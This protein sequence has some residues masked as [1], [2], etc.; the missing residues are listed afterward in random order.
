MVTRL[1][2]CMLCLKS[3]HL[4]KDCKAPK[5]TLCQFS[6]HEMLHR[7]R[8]FAHDN[9]NDGTG[10]EKAGENQ[11]QSSLHVS[12]RMKPN[13]TEVFLVTAK[14]LV[15]DVGGK[16][17]DVRVILDSAS[18]LNLVYEYMQQTLRLRK[19]AC[20]MGVSLVGDSSTTMSKMATTSV[21]SLEIVLS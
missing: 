6:H 8:E 12:T 21:K 17:H 11:S 7:Q 18:Q 10:H 14:I 3:G 19:V 16:Y 9:N 13:H 2:L 15:K 4:R 1:R 5:C 20:T